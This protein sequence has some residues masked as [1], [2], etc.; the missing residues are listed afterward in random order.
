MESLTDTIASFNPVDHFN[1]TLIV[2]GVALVLSI[3]ALFVLKCVFGLFTKD[4]KTNR[5]K[6][7]YT[8]RLCN[9]QNNKNF[10]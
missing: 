7:V 6:A 5:K 4:C 9:L 2:A 3:I 8:M 1:R 10:V